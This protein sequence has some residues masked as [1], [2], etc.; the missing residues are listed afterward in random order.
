MGQVT[1]NPKLRHEPP[2]M[3]GYRLEQRPAIPINR[4]NLL[5]IPLAIMFGAVFYVVGIQ[6][7]PAGE[8]LEW[9]G[10]FGLLILI[11]LIL[12]GVPIAHE[13]VHGVVARLLGA[14]PFYGIGSGFAYTSFEEP[15][16]P[17]QYRLITVAPLLVLSSICIV[18][19][20]VNPDW[21]VFILTFAVINA[22]GAIG[23]LWILWS[24]RSLPGNAIIY[25]LADGYAAFVPVPSHSSSK[26]E[27]F[28]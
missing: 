8:T 22:A 12:I 25:D 14:R 24:I 7:Q 16:S 21:F 3:P 4:L 27:L 17:R 5:S 6:L 1:E 19:F 9:G 11:M 23:D 18:L 10:Y 26:A 13:A 20:P 15:V 28:S 2:E